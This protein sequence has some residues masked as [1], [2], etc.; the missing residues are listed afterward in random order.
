MKEHITDFIRHLLIYDYLLFGGI[1]L[2]F[3]LVLILAI[4]LRHKLGLAV[5]LVLVAFGILTAGPVAGY[6]ILHQ[7]LFKHAVVMQEAK[8]LEFTEALLI[9]GEIENR[10]KRPFTECTL[11]AGVHKVTHN[12]FLDPLYPSFPF[13]KSSLHLTVTIKP[14][15]SAPFKLFVEPFRYSKE[16]NITLK[17]NCR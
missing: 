16:Y 13:K 4:V 1:I 15:E 14:G 12:R 5:F 11:N 17:A 7:Y 6:L 8:A 2:V 10:S 9:R 3:I